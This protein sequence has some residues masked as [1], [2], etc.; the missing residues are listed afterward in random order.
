MIDNQAG[1]IAGARG[2]IEH[3]QRLSWSNPI[4]QKSGDQRV[5]SEEPIQLPQ[6]LQIHFQLS[7][8]RLRK[9]HQLRLSRIKL[10]LH[11]KSDK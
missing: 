4:A 3:A 10:A 7:G 2:E 6:I 11:S 8:D 1:N 9:I 5:A